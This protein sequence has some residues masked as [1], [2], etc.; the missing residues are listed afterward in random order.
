VEAFVCH[1]NDCRANSGAPCSAW[2]KINKEAFSLL[3]GELKEISSSTGVTWLFA[4]PVARPS[5]ISIRY[6][7]EESHPYIDFMLCTLD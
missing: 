4:K 5:D 6:Q 7:G 2:G 1:C 3:S